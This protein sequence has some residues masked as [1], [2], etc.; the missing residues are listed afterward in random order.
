MEPVGR[1][2]LRVG[3]AVTIAVQVEEVG[4]VCWPDQDGCISTPMRASNCD[5]IFVDWNGV[6]IGSHERHLHRNFHP[7]TEQP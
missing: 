6:S 7:W 5:H 3:D 4:G 1:A 2:F